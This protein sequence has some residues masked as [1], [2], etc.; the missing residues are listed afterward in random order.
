MGL[1]E[2]FLGVDIEFP[3]W[4]ARRQ[5]RDSML[6]QFSGIAVSAPFEKSTKEEIVLER[7]HVVAEGDNSG[8]SFIC[9]RL[10]LLRHIPLRLAC[11]GPV[12]PNG[13]CLG[14]PERDLHILVTQKAFCLYRCARVFLDDVA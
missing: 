8:A 3:A 14:R 12:F 10:R 7:F 11:D 13:F 4:L 2:N 5:A 9:D 6:L 1:I